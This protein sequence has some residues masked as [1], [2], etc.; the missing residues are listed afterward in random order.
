MSFQRR[1]QL[2]VGF[3]IREIDE[4]LGQPVGRRTHGLEIDAP[5]VT[6]VMKQEAV[7]DIGGVDYLGDTDLVVRVLGE[8]GNR[9]V[10]QPS[11]SL[12]RL[13]RARLLS[14]R[15]LRHCRSHLIASAHGTSVKH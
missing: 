9:G 12:R 1:T 2:H 7:R 10:D 6:E 4:R 15:G 14:R 5:L 3:R 13:R 8:E 11:T